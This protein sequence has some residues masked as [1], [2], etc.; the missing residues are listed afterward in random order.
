VDTSATNPA[1]GPSSTD[2]APRQVNGEGPGN[3][4]GYN[5]AF[6]T[7]ARTGNGQLALSYVSQHAA[8]GMSMTDAWAKADASGMYA[9]LL[10]GDPVG[11]QRWRELVFQTSHMAANQALMGAY[12]AMAIGEDGAR[13]GRDP[14][15][16]YARAAQLIAKSYS[17]VPDGGQVTV[18]ATKN[19]VWAQRY[20]EATGIPI[21]SPYQITARG[22]AAGMNQTLDPQQF[23]KNLIEEQKA[24][25]DIAYK[26]GLMQYHRDS[27]AERDKAIEM[28]N[29][30]RLA[31]GA[32]TQNQANARN[33]VTND[34]RM[35]LGNKADQLRLQQIESAIGKLYDPYGTGTAVSGP[36]NGQSITSPQN[37]QSRT[38]AIDLAHNG[39]D[40]NL[41]KAIG[42]DLASSRQFY[43]VRP[44]AGGTGLVYQKANGATVGVLSP[45]TM[46]QLGMFAPQQQGQPAPAP[47]P[48]PPIGSTPNSPPPNLAGQRT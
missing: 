28:N 30:T 25:A 4:A 10:R 23:Y 40:L 1:H 2:Q 9:M 22:I 27:V 26:Q 47:L 19:G 5:N 15:G 11:A 44:A 3:A 29:D 31:I 35:Q 21:G 41:S 18:Q 48:P 45:R 32:N 46:Q 24:N 8:P 36:F 42:D 20:N 43:G 33:A 16:D 34:T 7:A 14:T 39:A 13:N 37:T 12:Q 38:A 6:Q 17:A